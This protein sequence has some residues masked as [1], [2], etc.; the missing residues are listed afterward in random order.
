M[1]KTIDQNFLN[2]NVDHPGKLIKM[3]IL[4]QWVAPGIAGLEHTLSN[5]RIVESRELYVETVHN[6]LSSKSLLIMWR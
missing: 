2:I 3:Q 6:D 5:S 4:I 1:Y